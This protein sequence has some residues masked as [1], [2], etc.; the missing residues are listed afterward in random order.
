MKSIGPVHTTHTSGSATR[1]NQYCATPSASRTTP[2]RHP[3][4]P[5][6]THTRPAAAHPFPTRHDTHIHTPLPAMRTPAPRPPPRH[7]R[8]ATSSLV[9]NQ[10]CCRSWYL[11]PRAP[12]RNACTCEPVTCRV[13]VSQTSE[14]HSVAGLGPGASPTSAASDEGGAH[15]HR[16]RP[17]LHRH[18]RQLAFQRRQLRFLCVHALHDPLH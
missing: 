15:A 12:Q 11:D 8:G 1:I 4:R 13:P 10:P 3:P 5:E 18:R 9:T 14:P 2:R 6:H 17:G 7:L 16:R